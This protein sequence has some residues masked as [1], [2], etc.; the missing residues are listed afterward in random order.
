MLKSYVSICL[1]MG[2]KAGMTS[3]AFPALG[4]GQL[5]YPRDQ[6]ASAM[7]EE[8]RNFSQSNRTTSL[9]EVRFSVFDQPTVQVR[10]S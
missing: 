5:G 10:T 3:I 2:H 8:V 7:F 4:T 6:V 1:D 9:K